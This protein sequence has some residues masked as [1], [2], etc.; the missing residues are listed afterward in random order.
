MPVGPTVFSVYPFEI[1]ILNQASA[2]ALIY[3]HFHRKKSEF[4]KILEYFFLNMLEFHKG[5]F[6]L[7]PRVC[8]VIVFRNIFG[9]LQPI[10]HDL[11]LIYIDSTH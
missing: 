4:E 9:T 10:F 2:H 5:I 11:Q 8:S 7:V 1:F 6:F 3:A